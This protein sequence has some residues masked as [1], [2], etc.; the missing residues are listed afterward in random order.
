MT[1]DQN[2]SHYKQRIN[3]VQNKCCSKDGNITSQLSTSPGYS[4]DTSG[5]LNLGL[6]IAS[7]APMP[8]VHKEP[9]FPP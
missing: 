3:D 4:R 5:E 1:M 7:V 9:E 2:S 6:D 8:S